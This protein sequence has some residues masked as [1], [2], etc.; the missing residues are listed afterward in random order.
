MAVAVLLTFGLE[1]DVEG[2]AL[3]GVWDF[4]ASRVEISSTPS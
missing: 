1:V 3:F 2:D 4:D